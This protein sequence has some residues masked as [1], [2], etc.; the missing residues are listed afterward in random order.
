MNE[1]S[2]QTM[3]CDGRRPLMLEKA[4][5]LSNEQ[6]APGVFLMTLTAPRCATILRPG[7]FVHLRLPQPTD[8]ILRLPFSVYGKLPSLG[9]IELLYQVLGNGTRRMSGLETGALCD[10]IGP[11][12]NGWDTERELN[13]VLLVS[14]GL[15]AAPLA[16]LAE[17]LGERGAH[18]DIVMG[19]PS[20]ARLVGRDRLAKW[21]QVQVAT[22][23][24]SEGLHGFVTELS[25]RLILDGHYDLIATCGPEPME[26]I[27]AGQA[28]A[29]GLACQVSLEKLMACGVGACLSCVV[30][31][32]S[33]K[34]R[35]CVDGPIF[36]GEEV[37]WN[38]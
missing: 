29:A 18:L 20:A 38:V 32:T 6:V 1:K 7:Q 30:Q 27:V 35:V 36:D 25:D 28:Q 31:T 21:G 23:D 17:E 11:I 13:D 12:G 2:T 19:A 8:E 5:V 14:G 37:V 10:I 16:L 3:S 9:A 34:K 24:G 26:M 4:Q 22:D 15:G 33:G